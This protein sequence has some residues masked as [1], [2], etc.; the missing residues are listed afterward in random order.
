MGNL[1]KE[2]GYCHFNFPLTVNNNRRKIHEKSGLNWGQRPGRELNQAYIPVPKEVRKTDFFPD[3]KI[4]FTVIT[5]DG[6][7]FICVVAQDDNKALETC[8]DNSILGKY[9]RNRLGVP[10][11]GFVSIEDLDR[12]GR[13]YVTIYK[14]NN[15]TY[16]MDFS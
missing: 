7:S 15:E 5:D 12:Y 16:F 14:I 1:V 10:L 11:G 3:K 13:H 9:F 6:E 4:E 8:R 2:K